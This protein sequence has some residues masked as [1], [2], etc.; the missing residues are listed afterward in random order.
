LKGIAETSARRAKAVVWC[1]AALIAISIVPA[2]G[3]DSSAS[4]GTLFDR[5]SSASKATDRLHREFGGD[6]VLVVV[7]T[8]RG[9]C[10]GGRNCRLPDLLLTPDLV[11]LLSLEGCV[12][13]N[14]PRR[15]KSPAPVCDRFRESKPFE[16]VNGPGTFINESARQISARLSREAG[17]A[18]RAAQKIAAAKGLPAAKRKELGR[19]ARRVYLLNSTLRYGVSSGGVGIGDPSFVHELIFAPKISYDAPKTRFTQYFP[20]RTSAVVELRPRAGL[21]GS[22]ARA[23]IGLVREAVGSPAFRLKSARYVMTG[24]PVAA[25]AVA[26]DVS[27]SLL[28]LLIATIVVLTAAVALAARFTRLLVPLAPAVA[29]VALTFGFMSVLGAT[30][31]IASIAVL[32]VL[33]GIAAGVAIHF[34]RTGSLPLVPAGAAAIGFAVLVFSPVPMVRTFG[35]FVALGIVLSL[36]LTLTLGSALLRGEVNAPPPAGLATKPRARLRAGWVRLIGLAAHRPRTVLGI[37]AVAALLGWILAP[38]SEAVS[39]LDRLA[40][41]GVRE[42]KDLKALEHESRME[43]GV[44]LVVTADDL[45]DPKVIPWMVAYQ[46]KVLSR[47]GYTEDKPCSAAELCPAVALADL[48]GAGRERSRAQTRKLLD[49]LPRYFT[50]GVVSRDRRTGNISF[51]MRHMSIDRQRD[52]IA[53]LRRQIDPPAGVHA[54]LAGGTLLAADA[55]DFGSNSR[56]LALRALVALVVMLVAVGLRSLG[57][58]RARIGGAIVSAAPVAIAAGW[59]ALILLALRVDL[60]PMSATL[61]ALVVGLGGYGMIIVSGLYREARENGVTPEAAVTSAYGGGKVPLA[62]GAVALAGF[63]IL[64]VTDVRMLR[65]FGATAVLDLAIVLTG[66]L[67]VLPAALVWAEQRKPLNLPRSR[68]E[69]SAAAR[70]GFGQVRAAASRPLRRRGEAG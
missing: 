24:Q 36:L 2:L 65:S 39:G 35:A 30:L 18:D 6:P 54:E 31:T 41:G 3:L 27:D 43:S 38:Q 1:A 55:A 16:I 20:S 32:P 29:T 25:Q 17:L 37:A 66:A 58:I 51:L 10:P 63:A 21:S 56:T 46:Q 34:G 47:H 64:I 57:A 13:G 7:H 5:D 12:S 59:S 61:G 67:L 50:Q 45:T 8:R 70:A 22:D 4:P 69:W 53:D 44:N 60:N 48:F 49:E 28:V 40:S 14:I 26:D 11:R 9:G 42:V 23:A 33:A 15:A 19:N 52:M 62:S 68:A